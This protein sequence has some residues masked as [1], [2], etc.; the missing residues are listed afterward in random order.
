MH[1]FAFCC[2]KPRISQMTTDFKL[3]NASIDAFGNRK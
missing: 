3:N 2:A 1:F